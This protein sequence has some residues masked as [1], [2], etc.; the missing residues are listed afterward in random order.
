M[1]NFA[2][3]EFELPVEEADHYQFSIST[4][5]YAWK[6]IELDMS[7]RKFGKFLPAIYKHRNLVV[8]CSRLLG[9]LMSLHL[10]FHKIAPL[11]SFVF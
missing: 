6:C 9:T 2:G 11:E 4:V 7:H 5:L 8:S 10:K 3:T 1:L